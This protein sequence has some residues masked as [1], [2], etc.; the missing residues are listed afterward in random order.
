VE[1][2]MKDGSSILSVYRRL[3]AL[4]RE[5]PAL[6]DGEYLALNQSDPHVLC[7]LRRY[8]HDGKQTSVLVALNMSAE[9]QQVNFDLSAEGIS[10]GPVH[11]LLSTAGKQPVQPDWRQM[12]LEPF[13][14]Y[15]GELSK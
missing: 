14:A 3:L 15:V 12:S 13:E 5:N 9:K 6:R 11:T 7:Y 1:A 4:R 10:P 8:Q 2:E